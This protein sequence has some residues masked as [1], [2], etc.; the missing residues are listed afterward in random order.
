MNNQEQNFLIFSKWISLSTSLMVLI[1]FSF[2]IFTTPKSGPNCTGSCVSYPYN[3]ITKFF[4][5]DYIWMILMSIAIMMYL[6]F[7]TCLHYKTNN[8]RKIFSQI[9][10]NF[11]LLS[12][13]TLVLNYVLQILVI[14]PSLSNG[15]EVGIALL[16]Q[17]NVHG[18]FIAMEVIGYIFMAISFAFLVPTLDKTTK[19]ERWIRIILMISVIL[20]FISFVL[21]Y[22]FYGLE[23]GDKFEVVI[24]VITWS[25]LII[26]GLLYYKIFKNYNLRSFEIGN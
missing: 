16:T 17:Y 18:V 8:S 1:S 25:V 20:S 10:L 14:Q 4:P 5:G 6:I 24:I 11:A 9:A 7:F 21:L 22:S 19:E 23:T 26:I 13:L 2:A 12:T 3:D 15:E